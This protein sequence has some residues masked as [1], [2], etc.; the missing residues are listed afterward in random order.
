MKKRD[1][2]IMKAMDLKFSKTVKVSISIA[3]FKNQAMLFESF[4]INL[5]H[6]YIII[7]SGA[8]TN[9]KICVEV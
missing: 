2:F 7:L 9:C 1:F 5:Q 6:V 3:N 8:Q 4:D